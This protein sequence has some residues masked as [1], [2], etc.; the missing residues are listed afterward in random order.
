[1]R[2]VFDTNIF[3]SA[4]V[5]PESQAE[6]A[7]L[8]IIEGNDTLLISRDI[9]MEVLSVLSRKFSRDKEQL[10][11]VAVNLSELGELIEATKEISVLTDESDN[12]IL[13]CA[14]S[15]NADA[16]VTGDKGILELRR[17]EN[18]RIMSL[19]EYLKDYNLQSH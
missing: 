10:S 13:E 19:R 11:R 8:K 17:F 14:V 6:K 7:I 18:I 16:I 2:V 4:F 9:I 5:F 15:G 12:R 3:I 1:M